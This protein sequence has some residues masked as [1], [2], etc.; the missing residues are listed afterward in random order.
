MGYLVEL[1]TTKSSTIK[2]LI[3]ILQS[4]YIELNFV[5]LPNTVDKDGNKKTGGLMIKEINKFRTLLVY[6]KLE[7]DMFESFKFNSDKEYINIGVN[8]SY[9]SKCLKCMANYDSLMMAI[10]END[11]DNLILS[12]E[13][14]NDKKVIKLNLMDLKFKQ[15]KVD[16]VP[17]SY[18]C[19][20]ASSD[21]HKYCKDLLLVSDKMEIKC[22]GN[23]LS[24]SGK[25]EVGE[26]DYEILPSENGLSIIRDEEEQEDV[27]VQG[28]Y[29]LKYLTIFTKCSSFSNLFTLYL[30]NDV[31]LILQYNVDGLGEIKFVLAQSKKKE[32]ENL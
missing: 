9:L 10:D 18:M 13:N 29:D 1:H 5:F 32:N 12:L 24:L 25:G 8:L 23:K 28:I 2:T 22:N 7:A 6:T 27:I 21:F 15:F 4:L 31:A 16:T 14:A 3:E 17:A 20:M 11:Q 26:I 19:S 30:K